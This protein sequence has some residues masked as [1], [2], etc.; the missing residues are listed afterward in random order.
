MTVLTEKDITPAVARNIRL[1]AGM[2]QSG[3]W[4]PLGVSQSVGCRYEDGQAKIPRS[5]RILIVATYVAGVKIDTATAGGVQELSKFG[6]LQARNR[7][8]ERAAE[9][10]AQA[11]EG[12]LSKSPTT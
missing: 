7:V 9:K 11:L 1:K 12:V 10:A 3:F 8:I 6:A 2:S 5:V 4:T